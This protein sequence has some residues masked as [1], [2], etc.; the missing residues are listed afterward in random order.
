[1]T[2]GPRDALRLFR[3]QTAAVEGAG[4]PLAAWVGGAPLWTLPV[5]A[6][7][8]VLCHFAGF[9]ENSLT[10]IAYDRLDP[11]KADHPVV[12]GRVS[13]RSGW[14]LVAALQIAG[15]VLMIS[16]VGVSRAWVALAPFAGYILLGHAYNFLGKR[17][18]PLAVL[19]ISGAFAL[20]FL[21]SAL[22]WGRA[23]GVLV[24]AVVV[25][26][27]AMTAF[28]IAVAGET[29]ELAQ[30]NEGNILRRL[31][32]RIE[33][34]VPVLAG[35][36]KAAREGG[37]VVTVTE[38]GAGLTADWLFPGVRASLFAYGLAGGK[39]LA[40]GVVAWAV[41]GPPWGIVVGW[42]SYIV[43]SFY[44]L[45]LLRPGPFDRP[46]RVRIMGLGEATSYLLLVLALVPALW[47][48]LWVA[49]IVLPVLWFTVLNR[50]L[51]STGSAWAPGV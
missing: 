41:A 36:L 34:P 7:L 10:D 1:M 49:F 31:G 28:Q 27:F 35:L 15:I 4:F 9:G 3:A 44:A 33:P 40:L 51:W 13:L 43:F 14:T 21:A 25:Y 48:W 23:P 19:E 38:S 32:A 17:N 18:K 46:R 47:P 24:W 29:K 6:L 42:A 11:A 2:V 12:A 16:L 22:A 45:H 30:A 39:A 26:A 5:F 50:A 20:A 8:G 37:A